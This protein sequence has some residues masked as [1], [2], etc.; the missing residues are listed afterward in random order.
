MAKK[1]GGYR[2][3]SPTPHKFPSAVKSTSFVNRT[4]YAGKGG[5]TS[6]SRVKK[7]PN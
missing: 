6:T 5:M 7:A 3:A 4:G 1:M 2:T